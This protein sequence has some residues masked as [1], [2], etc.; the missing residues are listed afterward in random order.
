[1]RSVLYGRATRTHGSDGVI[2]ALD[3]FAMRFTGAT[4]HL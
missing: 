2:E 3:N 1:M 4:G